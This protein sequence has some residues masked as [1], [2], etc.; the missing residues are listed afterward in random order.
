MEFLAYPIRKNI[1]GVWV[2]QCEQGAEENISTYTEGGKWKI[3]Q[4]DRDGKVVD[5]NI[6]PVPYC[7]MCGGRLPNEEH[8]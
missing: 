6:G 2:H 8:A 1:F 7:P 4:R 5:D 3:Q